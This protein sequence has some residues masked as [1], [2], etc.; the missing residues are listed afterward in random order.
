L[1]TRFGGTLLVLGVPPGDLS[2]RDIRERLAE[3]MKFLR[4]KLPQS[5]ITSRQEGDGNWGIH[6]HDMSPDEVR[7]LIERGST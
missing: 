7:A 5:L 4:E 3:E 6:I 2:I 1:P